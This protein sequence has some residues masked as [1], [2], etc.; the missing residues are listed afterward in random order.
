MTNLLTKPLL[1]SLSAKFATLRPIHLHCNAQPGQPGQSVNR[2]MPLFGRRDSLQ[3]ARHVRL[4]QDAQD[5]EMD[6]AFNDSDEAAP[7]NVDKSHDDEDDDQFYNASSTSRSGHARNENASESSNIEGQADR[8]PLLASSTSSYPPNSPPR[9]SFQS[10]TTPGAYDFELSVAD[11]P[12]PSSAP[13]LPEPPMTSSALS[14]ARNRTLRARLANATNSLFGRYNPLATSDPD[15][16]AG[17]R[18]LTGPNRNDGVFANL[19]A[20]PERRR[21]DR[22][23]WVGGDDEGNGKEMPPVSLCARSICKLSTDMFGDD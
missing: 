20:K 2:P 14:A 22:Q 19:T 8:D 17:G 1:L 12:L 3:S 16:P 7:L 18:T 6:A 11:Q 10:R 15:A 5:D 23:E 9:T 13:V 4:S 21:E